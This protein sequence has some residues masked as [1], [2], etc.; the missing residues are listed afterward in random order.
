MNALIL[1][2]ANAALLIAVFV[3]LWLICL[4]TR[5]VTPIDSVW[6]LGMVFLGAASF[7]QTDGN[8]TRK[9]LLLGLCAVWGLRLG[10]YLLWRWRTQGPDRRYGKMFAMVE[11]AKGWG[12]ARASLLLVF[13]TQAPLLFIVCLP[14]QLGQI[15]AGP[16]L[17]LLGVAGAGVAVAGILFES[18]GDWQLIK[19]RRDPAN[20]AKVLETGLWRYTRHPNYFGDALTWWGL[21]LIAAETWTGIWALPGRHCSPGR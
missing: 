21:Y 3:L 14:A 10:C 11:E 6:A 15:D 17:G 18:I 9:A 16:P 2:A 13:A 1:L 7:L 19:F 8:P 5:D 12:F 4:R 20:A